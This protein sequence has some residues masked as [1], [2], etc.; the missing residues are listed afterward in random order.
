M[1]HEPLFPGKLA[2]T[3]T[4]RESFYQLITSLFYSPAL[5]YYLLDS[6]LALSSSFPCSRRNEILRQL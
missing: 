6:R 1:A 5:L 2:E 4:E 3:E